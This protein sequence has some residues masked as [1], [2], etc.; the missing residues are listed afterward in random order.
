MPHQFPHAPPQIRE[1]TCSTE[2]VAAPHIHIPSH[3]LSL[4][5]LSLPQYCL[6]KG[7]SLCHCHALIPPDQR[8]FNAQS[9]VIYASLTL[10]PIAIHHSPFPPA[11]EL[12]CCNIG[13]CSVGIL[14]RVCGNCTSD[15]S[16]FCVS[17]LV[18]SSVSFG[19]GI[20]TSC[21]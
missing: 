3:F 10:I 13:A 1:Q 14:T 18:P 17:S 15:S 11:P 8:R 16:F 20:F 19:F 12:A 5:P 9:N 6:Q 2:T 21:D 7:I 4:I